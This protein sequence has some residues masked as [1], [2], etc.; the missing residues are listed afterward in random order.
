MSK[1]E[2]L[3][4][5]LW[6]DFSSLS[7]IEK[8]PYFVENGRSYHALV[9]QQFSRL[10]LEDLCSLATCVRR[11]AKNRDGNRFLQSQLPGCVERAGWSSRDGWTTRGSS[12]S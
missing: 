12:T 11:I 2:I 10:M 4:Q 7:S 6:D 9:A 3:N 8:A 5:I 1:A